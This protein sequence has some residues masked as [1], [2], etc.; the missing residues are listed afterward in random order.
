[1][2]IE[3]CKTPSQFKSSYFNL[4]KSNTHKICLEMS[5][6]NWNDEEVYSKLLQDLK[7]VELEEQTEEDENEG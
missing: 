3:G 7:R 1:M 4:I 5:L 6:I 2:C